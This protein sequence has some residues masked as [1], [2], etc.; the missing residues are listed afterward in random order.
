MRII[1]ASLTV[2][3]L[4]LFPIVSQAGD[5]P[6]WTEKTSFIQGE[7]LYVVGVASHAQTLGAGRQL[8]LEHGKYEVMNFAQVTNLARKGLFLETQM[9]FEEMHV[10]GSVTVFRLFRVPLK[11]LENLQKGF[12]FHR[13]NPTHQ[14]TQAGKKLQ[15]FRHSATRKTEIIKQQ[16]AEQD[17]PIQPVVNKRFYDSQWICQQIKQGM[18][19]RQVKN[20]LGPAQNMKLI[21]ETP[22][23][24]YGNTEIWFSK[25]RVSHLEPID[26]CQESQ[27]F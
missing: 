20:L 23:L 5:R 13:P 24:Q 7:D 21:G 8:A 27:S 17:H 12:L 15:A 2:W 11:K 22:I 9:T 25:G 16:A 6:F 18:Q 26:H 10:D 19:M 3:I 4:V 14:L 1:G